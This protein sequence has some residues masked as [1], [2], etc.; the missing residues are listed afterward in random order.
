MLPQPGTESGID[1]AP[2]LVD[3][4]L[5]PL[6]LT[7]VGIIIWF[8]GWRMSRNGGKSAIKWVAIVVLA[9]AA[10]IGSGPFFRVLT[11]QAYMNDVVHNS[12]RLLYMG[13]YPSFLL[14]VV[15]II[16]FITWHIYD[17]K[18]SQYR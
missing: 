12:R 10:I 3:V 18:M 14:P 15:L 16:G 2:T 6:L 11:D 8:Y 9:A 13:F 1:A 17:A 7:A 4:A 5:L